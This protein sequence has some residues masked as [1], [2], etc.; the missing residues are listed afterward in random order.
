MAGIAQLSVGQTRRLSAE[1]CNHRPAVF[2]RFSSNRF[3]FSAGPGL[4]ARAVAGTVFAG[5]Y[6]VRMNMPI[7]RVSLIYN[8]CAGALHGDLS[9]IRQLEA[10]LNARGLHVDAHATTC[11]GDA[12]RLA[13]AAVAEKYDALIACGGDGTINEVAQELVG[14]Q[15]VLAVFPCGT[16]NVFARELKLTRDPKKVSQLIADGNA[17]TI[18][19]GRAFQSDPGWERYFLL[20]AGIGLDAAMVKNVNLNLKRHLGE[21]A[22]FFSALDYLVRWPLAEFRLIMDG[23]EYE[24]TYATIA[25]SPGYGGGFRIAP[26][27]RMDDDQLNICIFNSRS[28]LEYL[29]YAALALGGR[30]IGCAG[31]T[32]LEA[33]TI[34]AKSAQEIF[35]QLDGELAGTLPMR[36][37][38]V[39]HALRVIAAE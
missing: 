19:L 22:Y 11:G 39:P 1:D 33:Q 4:Q 3:V 15:T 38:V 27:A 7:N 25:N 26:G 18:S 16:A 31:V 24:A 28:R 8:P 5:H 36:F 34:A 9:S 12:T 2:S 17:R 32:Y 35:V 6:F 23:K 13:R 10:E 29:A 21:G 37:E 14:S 20:M 30:H